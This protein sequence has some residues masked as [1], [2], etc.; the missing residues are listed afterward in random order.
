MAREKEDSWEA[1]WAAISLV[2]A[3]AT[4][5]LTVYPA[6]RDVP[7]FTREGLALGFGLLLAATYFLAGLPCV[8]GLKRCTKWFKGK[9]NGFRKARP[10][11]S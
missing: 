6:L 10:E 11:E 2:T 1:V 4:A 5:F 8:A 7:G 3:E 9:Y